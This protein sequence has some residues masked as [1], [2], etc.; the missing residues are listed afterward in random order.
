MN[1]RVMIRLVAMSFG[2]GLLTW[3]AGCSAS[4]FGEALNAGAQVATGS[5]QTSTAPAAPSALEQERTLGGGVALYAF[6]KMGRRYPNEDLQ[7][8][9]TMVGKAV[10]RESSRP[11]LPYAFAVIDNPTPD[12]FSGP[13]GYIFVT[14]GA[15]E[16]MRSEAEL[17]G[18]LAHEIAHVTEG[19]LL[20]MYRERND[21]VSSEE[22]VGKYTP[23]VDYASKTLWGE[24][25][26]AEYEYQA[27]LL[28]TEMAALTGYDPNG[29]RNYVQ[30]LE[31]GSGRGGWY[32]T[33]PSLSER[34]S[35]LDALLR[36]N[37]SGIQ[38]VEQGERFNSIVPPALQGQQ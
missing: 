9:V 34:V 4:E 31:M 16:W 18:V 15:L 12:S 28:G 7:R 25:L 37:L 8:Y 20:R 36:A 27:D 11:E 19:H 23:L 38:G 30:R 5:Q 26:R 29:L 6:E 21:P 2:L 3:L 14:S 35:R 22:G 32:Q 13:G 10:A 1:E 17:A 24:G 33:H